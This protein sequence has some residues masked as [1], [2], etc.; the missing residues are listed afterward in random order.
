MKHPPALLVLGLLA[1]GVPAFTA[2][3]ETPAPPVTHPA[4]G[5]LSIE[6]LTSAAEPAGY[7]ATAAV[8]PPHQAPPMPTAVMSDEEVARLTSAAEPAGYPGAAAEPPNGSPIPSPV[9]LSEEE[10]ARLTSAVEPPEI[11]AARAASARSFP[12]PPAILDPAEAVS[13]ATQPSGLDAEEAWEP[14]ATPTGCAD[15]FPEDQVEGEPDCGPDYVDTTNGGCNFSPNVFQ[16][17]ECGTICGKTGTY[18][19]NGQN[20]RDTDWYSITVGAG[21]Y[22]FSGIADGFRLRLFVMN[23]VCPAQSIGTTTAA[24]CTQSSALTFTGPGTFYLFAS[25]D[26]FSGVP[27]GSRYRLTITG[28]GIPVCCAIPC[29]STSQVEGEPECGPNYVDTTNGGCNFSPNV[30]QPVE[31]GTICGET[32]TYLNNGQ[33]FRDTDWYS[34]TVGAGTYTFSGISSGFRLRLF[35]MNPVCPAQSIGTTT[36]ASCTQSSALTFTG[37]GTFYLFASPDVFSGVPCGSRYRLTI[38]GPEVPTCC[39]QQCPPNA[40]VEG[41]PECGPNYVDTTNGGCNFSPNVFQPVECGTICGETGTYLNNGQNF[42]DTDWYSITVGAGTYTF[43]GISSGFR[44]R[45]F[46]MNPVCP[47]QSI[48]TTAAESCT[49]SSALTFTGPGT[50]YLFASPDV[51]SGVPC[52]SRY[53]LTITGPEVPTCCVQQ[54]PP[55]AQVEGEPECGPNYVDTTN[56]GCNFSPNVFQPV[57]CGTICG[58]TGTYLNN[59]QN[60]RDTDWYSIT[61]GAGTYTFSGISSGFR[62]RLFVMNPVCPAQS[63]GTTAAESC[64][65]SSALTF[66]GPGTFYL[67]A[68][69]DVFSGVPCG[70]RYQLTIT[71]PNVPSCGVVAVEDE[72]NGAPP[73]MA[74]VAVRPNPFNPSTT[75]EYT[76]PR[77]GQVALELH[78]ASGRLV[79]TLVDEALPAGGHA[80]VWSGRDENGQAAPAGIYLYSLRLDGRTL[81]TGKAVL[82]K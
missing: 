34:I 36:A 3:A 56:G 37:P 55:N 26:V 48:G 12:A 47:A 78:D 46:V 62:L 75:F 18:L 20:F 57:E 2:R 61:V 13:S 82:L 5:I 14:T 4:A 35:V 23:P 71:G 72:A 50:F 39:V 41:E 59:G 40:Q 54:C 7:P 8:T 58:E 24:S 76:I 80:V 45:L 66:T 30:F 25:P 32:G 81:T 77:R 42:R 21:T 29:P 73:L 16:P 31:C 69:P 49:Q 33:N 53:Q 65:Q 28:P 6:E 38:T 43:S 60:F 22:T 17:V 19:N 70:S 74:A 27:C 64:T 9:V 51:F 11:A 1:L 79:R 67:F 68:S 15:C 63:I 10:I 44:L 52:G